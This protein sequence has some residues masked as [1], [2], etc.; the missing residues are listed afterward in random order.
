MVSQNEDKIEIASFIDHTLLKASAS[1]R[2]M[3]LLCTEA[4]EHQFAAVCIYPH[5][6]PVCKK[7]IGDHKVA[8]CTV[9][10]F[11][12]GNETTSQ[13]EM[14]TQIAIDAGADEIDMVM[15]IDA[16]KT[17]DFDYVINE[18]ETIKSI[19]DE[20]ILKVIIETC[21]LDRQEKIDACHILRDAGADF[22][23]TSTGF[24]PS[25]ATIEDVKLLK[26]TVGNS[27]K[28]KAAGGIKTRAFAEALI[29]AGADRLGTSSSMAIIKG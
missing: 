2:Q 17:K 18:I 9:V 29:E 25:G 15:N 22:V 12:D 8:V 5:Y 21:Y 7:F 6:I 13:K 19:C 26:E 1:T 24:G 3:K 11:P 27:L 23:K 14:Q 28:I 4:I 10:G 16:F 20:K